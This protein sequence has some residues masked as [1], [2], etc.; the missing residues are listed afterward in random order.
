[1]LIGE[2][3]IPEASFY[4][5]CFSKLFEIAPVVPV[6]GA[7][8]SLNKKILRLNIHRCFLQ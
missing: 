5:R 6:E 1:V 3:I 7:E 8:I 2:E 4:E